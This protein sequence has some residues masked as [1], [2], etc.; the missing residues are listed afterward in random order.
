MDVERNA[1]ALGRLLE[2]ISWVGSSVRDYRNGGRGY[3]NVL[4]VEVFQSL[5]FLPRAF[6]LKEVIKAAHGADAARR[7]VLDEI[8]QVEVDLLP[9][10]YYLIPSMAAGHTEG[11]SVQPDAWI[12]GARSLV[13]VEAKRIRS[14]SFQREQLAR[15]LV[16]VTRDAR[17]SNRVPLLLLILG[18]EPPVQVQGHGKQSISDAI[19]L[20]LESVLLRAENHSLIAADLMEDIPESV[21]WITWTEIRDVVRA[22]LDSLPVADPSLKGGIVRLAQALI[23][24]VQWH[25]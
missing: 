17:T 10:N 21:A 15:E 5:D 20:H 18:K 7:V 8:E 13:L 4:T 6:F 24:A 16:L 19:E 12:S 23:R 2:E 25:A 1:S 9:G 22:Q 3:E 11:L 14:S